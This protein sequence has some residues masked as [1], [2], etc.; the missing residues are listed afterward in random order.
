MIPPVKAEVFFLNPHASF[1]SGHFL[2]DASLVIPDVKLQSEGSVGNRSSGPEV[3]APAPLP[4]HTLTQGPWALP[5]TARSHAPFPALV[6]SCM[7]YGVELQIVEGPS[8][9]NIL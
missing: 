5:G 7:Y 8:S 1:I 6:S 9:S 2:L 4:A 3:S